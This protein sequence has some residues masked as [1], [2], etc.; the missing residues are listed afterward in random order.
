MKCILLLMSTLVTVFS[1]KFFK[2]FFLNTSRNLSSLIVLN[3][4]NAL[5]IN[6]ETIG[7]TITKKM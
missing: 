5:E 6:M 2:L 3:I 4:M 1:F 7:N